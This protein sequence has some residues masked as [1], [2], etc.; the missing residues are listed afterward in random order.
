M[1]V[2]EELRKTGRTGE[3]VLGSNETLDITKTGD[4]KLT[5][6]SATCPPDVEGKI[7]SHAAEKGVP[8]YFYP[9]G[10]EDLGLAVGKPFLVSAIG[11]IDPGDSRVLEL[12]EL[13]DE[14]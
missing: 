12:G 9:G 14:D 7:R 1:N 5:I 3:I 10:S 2:D 8:L 4:S 13:S 11:V 6:L